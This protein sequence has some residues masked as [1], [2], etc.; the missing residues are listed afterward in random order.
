MTIGDIVN[1]VRYSELNNIV[2]KDDLD[3]IISFMNLGLIELYK[4]FPLRVEEHIIKLSDSTEI[5]S[6]PSDY[7]WIIAA[8]DEVMLPNSSRNVELIPVNEEDNPLGINTIGFN[9]IQV[10]LNVD[11]EYISIIYAASPER[12]Y[13][14][15]DVNEQVPV[16]PQMV[17]AL[18]SYIGYRAHLSISGNI[19][20]ENNVHYKRFED[21]CVEIERKGMY[22]TD[23]L[24]MKQ[25]IY[26]K[27]FV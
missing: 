7:M 3:A 16:P 14:A 6:M 19:Q 4:K 8:Y 12:I 15:A 13:T 20:N 18:L 23:D 11:G 26:D 25:R 10:P 5:Y 22:N 17:T 27:G 21:A 9:Q 1:L 2:L 24:S